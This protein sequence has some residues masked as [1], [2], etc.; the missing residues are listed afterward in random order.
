MVYKYSLYTLYIT[1]YTK[2]L[3][4]NFVNRKLVFWCYGIF[5]FKLIGNFSVKQ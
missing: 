1:T 4:K 3:L 2:Y 5:G